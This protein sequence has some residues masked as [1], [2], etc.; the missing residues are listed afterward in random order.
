MSNC[1]A[2]P[3]PCCSAYDQAQALRW[4]NTS[5]NQ[6]ALLIVL[7]SWS[8]RTGG[9]CKSCSHDEFHCIQTQSDTAQRMPA[10][11]RASWPASYC[12]KLLQMTQL[13]PACVDVL[14][15]RRCRCW[16]GRCRRPPSSGSAQY[17]GKWG[18]AMHDSFG[19]IM[20]LCF[21]KASRLL[22]HPAAPYC[23]QTQPQLVLLAT[24]DGKRS[25]LTST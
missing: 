6:V 25:I 14:H 4:P 15:H 13:R 2:R 8:T 20:R 5:S 17:P 9:N 24:H 21:R 10:A 16:Q 1:H 18:A 23:M 22:L 19:A 11:C 7:S 12:A 3:G